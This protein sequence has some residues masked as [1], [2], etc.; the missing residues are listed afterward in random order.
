MIRKRPLVLTFVFAL[1]SAISQLAVAQT[2]AVKEKPAAKS[3]AT[4]AISVVTSDTPGVGPIRTDDPKFRKLW[5]DRRT[6][7]AELKPEQMGAVVF[8]GDSITQGWKDDFRQNFPNLKLANRGISGDT[9]RGLIARIEED[10]LAQ[11][12][13]AIVML[14]GTNDI[15]RGVSPADIAAN[16]KIIFDKIAAH[17]L[18]TPVILCAVMPSSASK[19]RP[20]DKIRELN[21]CVA[22]LARD[23]KNVTIL[24][25]HTLF[26]DK[27]GDAPAD[28][29]PDL[30][31][32]NDAG[33]KKWT[34][35]L[36]P[37]LA[38]LGIVDTEPD[39]FKPEE[40][41]EL[42]FN[43]H[44]LDGW[45]YRR[46]SDGDRAMV[47]KW[48][49][50]GKPSPAYPIVDEPVSFD[51]ETASKDGR[52]RAINGRIVV[53]TPSEGR[54][55][56]QLAT[57][58]DF[59]GDFT[60][61]LDFRA[62]PNADSGVFIRGKQLQ[63][64]DY[65]LAGP[66]KDLKRYKPGDWNELEVKVVGNKAHCTCNGEVL[67]EAYELPE[68]GPIGLEGDRGQMEYRRIRIKS[69]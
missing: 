27:A 16:M 17:D 54:S 35:A 9:T 13:R 6:H 22:K 66:Y 42:L 8:F 37:L 39:T 2:A 67:E 24:D 55:I 36:L 23:Y 57:K 19:D 14:I 69:E 61:K 33:Y 59:S 45:S 32:P 20:A 58:R 12:P 64:R 65:P 15:G 50:S 7:F 29:F 63:C 21:E 56:Q 10:V 43:G 28:L 49:E 44:N 40:G 3:A 52:Y 31:H 51:G 41:F 68:K 34:A 4:A 38:T 25:T 60:L 48:K 30:L 53:T 62:T 1:I 11:K 46:T 47:K 18:K 5:I 26:A